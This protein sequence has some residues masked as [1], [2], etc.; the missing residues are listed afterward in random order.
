[1][2]PCDPRE[3]GPSASA[4]GE[5]G[6]ISNILEVAM[7]RKRNKEE[8]SKKAASA[9]GKVLRDPKSTKA[10][11]SAAA[12]ALTQRPNRSKKKKSR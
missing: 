11:K 6:W 9:A 2:S 3:G 12:S 1:M 7:P 10:E 4:I 8:T 5:H